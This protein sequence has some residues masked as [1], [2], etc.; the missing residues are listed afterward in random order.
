MN[1]TIEIKVENGVKTLELLTGRALEI[2]PPVKVAVLGLLDTPYKY[3]VK[4]VSEINSKSCHIWIDRHGR[5]INLVIDEHNE[6]QD[7]VSGGLSLN[8]EFL[9]FDINTGESRTTF[10]LSDFIKMNR[11]FFDS[12]QDAIKLVSEL[13]NFKAKVDKE[14]ELSDDN[15]GNKRLK[16]IQ[17]VESNIPESFKLCMPIFKGQEKQTFEVEVNISSDSMNS[18]GCVLVSPEIKDFIVETRDEL[19]DAQVKL[20]E[21]VAPELLIIEV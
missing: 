1:N 11:S 2:M 17:A 12:K 10:E 4:R 14:L 9:A 21:A 19:I 3:L 7:Q 13:R 8:P 16:M 18:F 20:I 6:Y 5:T 15:R